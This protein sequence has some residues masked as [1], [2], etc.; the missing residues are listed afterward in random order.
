[1]LV[2]ECPLQ[3]WHGQPERATMENRVA[4]LWLLATVLMTSASDSPDCMPGE[5][6]AEIDGAPKCDKCL[7]GRAQ[8]TRNQNFCSL[9]NAGNLCG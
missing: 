4:V 5:R 6:R 1:M 7:A 2:H 3:S 9:C 8:A